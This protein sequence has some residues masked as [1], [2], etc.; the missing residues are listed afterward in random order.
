MVANVP[1]VGESPIPIYAVRDHD[2][3]ILLETYGLRPSEGMVVQPRSDHVILTSALARNRSLG[4]GDAIG[5]PVHEQDGIPTELTVVG[6]LES[7]RPTLVDRG[8]YD[9]PPM[10]RWAGFASYEY[11]NSHERYTDIPTHMLIVPVKGR[12]A[13]LEV[14]LEET[15]A[16]PQ[17]KVTTLS[18]SYRLWQGAVQTVQTTSAISWTI[19]TVV[20]VLGLA[21]LNTI[22]V[23]QRRDEFGTLHAVG[24][25][26]TDLIRRTIGEGTSITAAAWLIG[27]A[28]CI[29]VM[30]L[31]QA[32]LYA[33]LGT[34]ID[35]F[36]PTPWLFTLPIPLAVVVASAGT[37][38]GMLSRLDPVA[39][40][41]RR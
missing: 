37:I 22:F 12:E 24:H 8:G 15:I 36:N 40:I 32:T 11:V 30:L 35:F 3:P 41:E 23:T 6:L 25:S 13:D 31:A 28:I 21:I 26:R 39:V 14:W 16:S 1:I 18:T 2:L 38:G 20:A 5:H 9:V 7:V 4:V 29:V 34:S 27:A 33:P 17:V 19:L 10:P